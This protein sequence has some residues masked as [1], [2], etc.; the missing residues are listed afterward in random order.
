MEGIW[1]AKLGA[2]A[3]WSLGTLLAPEVRPRAG[4]ELVVAH[5]VG[6]SRRRGAHVVWV[7]R[8]ANE[9]ER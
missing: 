5:P 1:R 6:E 2:A 8:L 7:L 9:G 3:G 4:E